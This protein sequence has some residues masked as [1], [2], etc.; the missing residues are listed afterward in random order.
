M[1]T[2]LLVQRLRTRGRAPGAKAYATARFV[3]FAGGALAVTVGVPEGVW[4]CAIRFVRVATG[5][6]TGLVELGV[7]EVG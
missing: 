3:G 4:A 7:V 5:Q 2:E 1:E 6:E